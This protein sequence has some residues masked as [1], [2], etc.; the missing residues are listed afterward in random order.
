MSLRCNLM[1][2]TRDLIFMGTPDF[3]ASILAALI[4]AGHRMAAV[5]T[6]PPRPSGRGHRP[7]PSP[8]QELAERHGLPVRCPTSLRQSEVQAEFTA[9]AADAAVVA[10]YGL[11]LPPP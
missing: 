10:A 3:A 11:I 5:Y 2:N 6:Q 1:R 8:V 4:A 9:I 7:L